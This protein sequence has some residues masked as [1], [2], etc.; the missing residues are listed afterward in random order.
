LSNIAKGKCVCNNAFESGKIESVIA[1]DIPGKNKK[2]KNLNAYLLTGIGQY[3]STGDTSFDDKTARA[4]CTTFA[5][6]DSTNHAVYMK[7]KGNELTGSKENDWK[8]TAP[9]LKKGALLVKD[10]IKTA[11]A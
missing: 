3:I 4:L 7:G 1:S 2:E 8:V 9:G 10:I 5:C 11:N 6:Y